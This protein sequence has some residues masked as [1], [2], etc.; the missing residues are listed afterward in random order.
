MK[1]DPLESLLIWTLIFICKVCTLLT[2]CWNV[3][4]FICGSLSTTTYLRMGIRIDTLVQCI[5]RNVSF[6]RW[7]HKPERVW[8][9]HI[10]FRVCMKQSLIKV[11]PMSVCHPSSTRDSLQKGRSYRH[12]ILDMWSANCYTYNE[13]HYFVLSRLVL[14]ENDDLWY[15]VTRRRVKI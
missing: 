9:P 13:L 15:W 10:F 8:N 5:L 1:W 3:T 6:S 4:I 7:L 14:F 11:G 2:V 12:E